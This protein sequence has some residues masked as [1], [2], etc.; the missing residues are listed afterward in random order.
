MQRAVIASRVQLTVSELGDAPPLATNVLFSPDGTLG[1]A[2]PFSF[3]SPL[4]TTVFDTTT[5]AVR[6]TIPGWTPN[7]SW[8][9]PQYL[10]TEHPPGEN[11]TLTT[12]ELGGAEPRA[13]SAVT[14]PV[15]FADLF[16]Y[17]VSPDRTMIA[18]SQRDRPVIV[19]SMEDGREVFV[20]DQAGA[21]LNNPAFSP[22]GRYL[23]ATAA[24][25]GVRV[26]Q[27]STGV[28]G[29]ATFTPA[30]GTDVRPLRGATTDVSFLAFSP[31]GS[32]LAAAVFDG[33]VLVWDLGVAREAET[34]DLTAGQTDPR[35]RYRLRGHTNDARFVAWSPDGSRLAS[36]SQ[37]RKI[38]IWDVQTGA[39]QMTL[40]GHTN[41]VSLLS[42]SADGTRL[43]SGSN[44]N[45]VRVWDVTPAYELRAFAAA[46]ATT[47]N[48]WQPMALSRDGRRLIA[49]SPEWPATLTV[50]DATSGAPLVELPTGDDRSAGVALSAD[51]SRAAT[52]SADPEFPGH[53]GS[54]APSVA[55]WDTA[56]GELIRR[57]PSPRGF[58]AVAL[59]PDGARVA[60]TGF[61]ASVQVWEVAGGQAHI[62]ASADEAIQRWPIA[63]SPDGSRIAASSASRTGNAS[64]IDVWNTADGRHLLRLERHDDNIFSLAFD[65]DGGRLASV[66]RD[67]TAKI[68]DLSDG[69]LLQVMT[70]HTSTVMGVAWNPDGTQIASAAFDSTIRLWDVATGQELRSF[71]SPSGP[72]DV[73]FSPDGKQLYVASVDGLVR[74]YLTNLDD[75]VA[76][77]RTRVTRGL[78]DEECRVYLHTDRCPEVPTPAE[79]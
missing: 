68:W 54:A 70:G 44:D 28:G 78:T 71:A 24:D 58:L 40:A 47:T 9:D 20:T 19:Y 8:P 31:D 6:Y 16:W 22:D 23:A 5:G 57:F 41:S 51:G 37:D 69:S 63:F 61:D 14:L 65:H 52:A 75:L 76:L 2:A 72:S 73:A 10:L 13:V 32:H 56:T 66:S 50:F 38:I 64:H 77:A 18:V 49:G 21:Q 45:S 3:T 46:P 33:T 15:A 79:K 35:L 1:L 39:Q 60:A 27:R 17:N 74:V 42:F 62:L 26:W 53:D 12:W 59:S 34:S 48:F 7:L 29:E 11:L 67:G 43:L 55:V 36:S 30:Y 25:Y 4:T